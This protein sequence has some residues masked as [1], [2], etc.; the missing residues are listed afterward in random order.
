MNPS[1]SKDTED[2]I[3]KLEDQLYLY[4]WLMQT[5]HELDLSQSLINNYKINI[6]KRV[7]FVDTFDCKKYTISLIQR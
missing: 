3:N 5:K 7:T 1:F 6:L 2:I 4:G